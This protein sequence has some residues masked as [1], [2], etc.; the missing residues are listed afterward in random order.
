LAL[1]GTASAETYRA[2][3]ARVEH[4]A[5]I[6]TVIPEDRADVDVSIAPGP[7]LTAP[8]VRLDGAT[9]V[10]DGGL[11]NRLRGC[12]SMW[13]GRTHVRI[14][15]IGAVARDEL[16]RITL[17]TPRSLDLEIGGA[18][19]ATVGA[20]QGGEITLNGCG[21]TEIGE[22]AGGLD[23]N[24]NGS[25]D[26][27]A[28]RVRGTLTAALNGSGELRVA[29]ADAEAALRLNGSGDLS[30]GDVGGAVDARVNGS[31]RV[32]VGASGG[33]ANLAL[34]GSGDID[35]G[36]VAGALD[37]ELRGSGSVDVASVEGEH[38]A[39]DLT[40]SGDIVV[41]G[42]RVAQFSAR[43]T[44]SGDIRYAGVAGASR[45]S[46]HGS[47]SIAVAD[48]GRIDQLIDSGSGGVRL[49]H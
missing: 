22:A 48:A 29:R 33:S 8:R 44:G 40:S 10:I 38:A 18:V 5:A 24:L 37:V 49:G 7:R 4:A 11:R 45:I 36:A 30:V 47:G 21:D 31:G 6:V 43:N 34:N 20:S 46:L 14:A 23:V 35:A 41:R 32:R 13:G 25:G 3:G 2:A 19:Y 15:G 9:V 28:E 27:D 26:V 42:G 17:R 1:V 12:T 16:P 39:L